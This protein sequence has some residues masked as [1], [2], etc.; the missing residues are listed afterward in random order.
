[1]RETGLIIW[2]DE[3]CSFSNV[4]ICFSHCLRA[5]VV[6]FCCMH[7]VYWEVS[8]CSAQYSW[9][10][11]IIVGRGVFSCPH[12]D[13]CSSYPIQGLLIFLEGKNHDGST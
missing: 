13:R 1:M 9:L 2:H 10:S 8:V 4:L 5:G 3:G 6:R 11:K 7:S 12:G